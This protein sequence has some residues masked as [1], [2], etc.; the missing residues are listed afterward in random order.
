MSDVFRITS[1]WDVSR[2]GFFSGAV[3]LFLLQLL[4]VSDHREKIICGAVLLITLI[5]FLMTGTRAPLL[6]LISLSLLLTLSD[7]KMRRYAIVLILFL[8]VFAGTIP[9]YQARIFSIFQ[10]QLTGEKLVSKNQSNLDRFNMWKVAIDFYKEQPLLGTGLGNSETPLRNYLQLKDLAYI[11]SYV[12]TGF[13]YRDQHSSYLTALVQ[14]GLIFTVISFLLFAVIFIKTFIVFWK[15]RDFLARFSLIG[16]SYC[17]IVFFFYSSL[18]SY[19][20]FVFFISLSLG[21]IRFSSEFSPIA[22]DNP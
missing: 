17:F 14:F 16:L 11:D 10:V 19:E 5:S 3:V 21:A 15:T 1:F 18:A 6:A 12:S 4:P 7:R 2:W 9:K 13:S 20:A 8:I 22:K